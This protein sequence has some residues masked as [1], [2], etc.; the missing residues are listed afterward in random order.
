[1][2]KPVPVQAPLPTD[3]ELWWFQINDY[4]G[5]NLEVWVTVRDTWELLSPVKNW[6]D[7]IMM[8]KLGR[9]MQGKEG[10][11]SF[12]RETPHSLGIAV[13]S[14]TKEEYAQLYKI[15]RVYVGGRFNFH[16]PE[17]NEQHDLPVLV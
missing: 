9:W 5:R 17:E 12:W 14:T 10:Q 3:E 6:G 16:V 8:L 15:W 7:R 13:C 1:M 4:G 11:V 2:W